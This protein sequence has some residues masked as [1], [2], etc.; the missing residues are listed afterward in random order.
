MND[1]TKKRPCRQ[2]KKLTQGICQKF[3]FPLTFYP[4]QTDFDEALDRWLESQGRGVGGGD[5][6]PG[7]EIGGYLCQVAGGSLTEA[8]R[9]LMRPLRCARQPTMRN[10]GG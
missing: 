4:Q 10:T 7:L 2:H 3:G 1:P 9:E 8:D 6:L 5:A